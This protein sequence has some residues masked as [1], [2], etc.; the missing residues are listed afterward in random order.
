[1][2]HSTG[3]APSLPT[4]P[5]LGSDLAAELVSKTETSPSYTST[6]HRKRAR[7]KLMRVVWEQ[8]RYA[9]T[10][11]LRAVAL[12]LTYSDSSKF[13]KNHLSSFLDGLRKRLKAMGHKL[14]YAWVL[15]CGGQL[16]YH[17]VV[18]LPRGFIID[19]AKLAKWW[20]WG[21]TWIAT[22]RKVIAWARYMTKF[23]CSSKLPRG[24]HT[25]GYGGLD[26]PGKTAVSRAGLPRWLLALIPAH[27][28]ARRCPGGGWR[29]ISS[30]TIH[31]SPYVWTP[32]GIKLWTPIPSSL[33]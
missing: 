16:H 11:G 4:A 33:H 2:L 1:M 18:W 8:R 13:A 19:P 20:T 12:T 6:N 17:I 23:K 5:S 3:S 9:K 30:G 22:C 31:R 29:C 27:T 15:E 32:W 26:E 14:P 10:V 21:S 28:S 25:H 7:R 24:A